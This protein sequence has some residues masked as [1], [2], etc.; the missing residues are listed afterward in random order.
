MCRLLKVFQNELSSLNLNGSK[1]DGSWESYNIPETS[2]IKD[3]FIL[4]SSFEKKRNKYRHNIFIQILH[5][6]FRFLI[7][8]YDRLIICYPICKYVTGY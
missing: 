4:N 6:C 2:S 5:L 3:Q 1:V 7:F 8:V